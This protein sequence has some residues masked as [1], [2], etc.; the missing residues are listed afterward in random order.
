MNGLKHYNQYYQITNRYGLLSTD[1]ISA[2]VST[3]KMVT[4]PVYNIICQYVAFPARSSKEVGIEII[5]ILYSKKKL[6]VGTISVYQERPE[7]FVY[8][9]HCYPVMDIKVDQLF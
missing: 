1:T 9:T 2:P 8:H 7:E 5:K 3:G 6:Q 4:L